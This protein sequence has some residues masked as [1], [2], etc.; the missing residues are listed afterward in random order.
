MTMVGADV[1]ALR[2][3]S[4]LFD[5]TAH[6]FERT[7]SE[8]TASLAR[9]SW[10]GADAARFRS[11][12]NARLRPRLT[13]VAQDLSES[14]VRLR[15]EADEQERAS[16]SGG[17]TGG[18]RG[19]GC[20]GSGPGSGPG[21]PGCV[22][23]CH[24]PGL[25]DINAVLGHDAVRWGSTAVSI[26]EMVAEGGRQIYTTA[27]STVRG[28]GLLHYLSG[29]DDL[30]GLATH[31]GH[32]DELAETAAKFGRVS[33]AIGPLATGLGYLGVAAD[34]LS[35]TQNLACGDYWGAADDGV[36]IA[37][38]A[39]GLVLGLSNPVGWAVAG[40]GVLWAGAQFLSGDVPVTQRIGDFFGSLF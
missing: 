13:D 36:S 10:S 30:A 3:L 33:D 9:S 37:L 32:A 25:S 12:W 20:G 40:A 31:L 27:A 2:S 28:T 26:A 5:D 14:A 21:T 15:E 4:K 17:G 39:A 6:R 11:D 8:L 29:T 23:D 7:G 1:G 22:N 16:E 34:T 38:G 19:T 24:I 18:N 35:L